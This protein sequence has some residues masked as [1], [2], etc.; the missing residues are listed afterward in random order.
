MEST[1]KRTVPVSKSKELKKKHKKRVRRHNVRVAIV[2]TFA[3]L[4]I[5]AATLTVV[6]YLNPLFN[7]TRVDYS[8]NNHVE[9]EYIDPIIKEIEGTNI[10]QLSKKKILETFSKINYIDDVRI[11]RRFFPPVMKIVFEETT[12]Y[13]CAKL[14]DKYIMFNKDFKNLEE[15][16]AFIEGAPKVLGTDDIPFED[17]KPESRNNKVTSM[18]ECLDKMNKV[19][20]LEK[21]S[22]LSME[23]LSNIT[24]EYDNRFHVILGG[25]Y[26]VEEKL[27][28][29]LTAIGS[30][31][32]SESDKGTMDLSTGGTALF[33]PE[34]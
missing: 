26:D 25:A 33:S 10:F 13:G 21:V 24:F 31:N 16:I 5:T 7:V 14:G 32:I 18:M 2:R 20:I 1:E 15:S 22:E 28:L 27:L 23:S 9:A 19:G 11:Y 3:V 29:F 17:F 6:L 12:P 8:G 30:A 34:K 4:F